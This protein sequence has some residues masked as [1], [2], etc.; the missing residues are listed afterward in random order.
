MV[1]V[2][3]QYSSCIFQD[4]YTSGKANGAVRVAKGDSYR[5]PLR[6]VCL[7][8]HLA[9]GISFGGMEKKEGWI[10]SKKQTIAKSKKNMTNDKKTKKVSGGVVVSS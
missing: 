1:S 6:G 3:S 8:T 10:I 2:V 9:R 7:R 4:T 5:N